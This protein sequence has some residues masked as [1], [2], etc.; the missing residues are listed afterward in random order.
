MSSVLSKVHDYIMGVHQIVHHEVGNH[1]GHYLYTKKC[2]LIMVYAI[3]KTFI[4]VNTH[5]QNTTQ[6]WHV[7]KLI[8]QILL[9]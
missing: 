7:N 3:D 2:T 9:I 1:A 8:F 4:T 6:N 5:L